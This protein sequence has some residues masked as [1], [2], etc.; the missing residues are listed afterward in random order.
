MDKKRIL[1]IDDIAALSQM[2]VIY[3][4]SK[5]FETAHASDGAS[6]IAMVK[7]F[8]PN[9]VLLDVMMPG[10]N[11]VEVLRQFRNN[12]ETKDLPV[13]L[14]TAIGDPSVEK[15]AIE[16]GASAYLEKSETDL[17]GLL[18][19]LQTVLAPAK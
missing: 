9:A 13:I 3:L 8:R 11:G 6:G 1:I 12:P 15:E 10:M 18:T 17:A 5:G 2:Y 19:K 4:N 14:L 16:L 7:D